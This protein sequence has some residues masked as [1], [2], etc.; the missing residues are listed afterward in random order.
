MRKID[1]II[2]PFSKKLP[3]D[4]LSALSDFQEGLGLDSPIEKHAAFAFKYIYSKNYPGN[5]ARDH[6]EIKH[7][8]R[9]A[10][11]ALVFANLYRKHGDVDAQLKLTDEDIKLIQIAALFHDSAREDDG[12]DRWDEESATLLYIY[13]TRVLGVDREKASFIAEAT[14]NK[15]ASPDVYR[16]ISEDP[17][18]ETIWKN[19]EMPPASK[20]IYQKIIHDADCL[21]IIRAR[22]AFDATYLDFYKEIAQKNTLAF[23]EMAMFITEAR[24]L[25]ELQGDSYQTLNANLKSKYNNENAYSTIQEDIDTSKTMPILHQLGKELL[26][27]EELQTLALIDETPYQSSKGFS[28]ENLSAALKEGRVFM[29]GIAT[30]SA[31]SRKHEETLAALEL[32]KTFREP[33]IETQSKKEN[34]D[35]KS[36]N[37]SRSIAMAAFGSMSYSR[38]GFV[39]LDPSIDQIETVYGDD[40]DT[41]RAKKLKSGANNIKEKQLALEKLHQKLQMGGFS[42]NFNGITIAHNEITCHLDRYDAM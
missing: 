12:V 18:G 22:P 4:S 36:G 29:R 2:L 5:K 20:N 16:K 17:N 7:V 24:G 25:I 42:R 27:L 26:P 38:S 8:S 39:V 13:L 40:A 35:K 31:V 9:V 3:D 1:K 10:E 33:S 34:R 21:D 37:P 15:D 14:A 28:D 11:Y 23:K 41:G 32:R 6:H 19:A 30:P